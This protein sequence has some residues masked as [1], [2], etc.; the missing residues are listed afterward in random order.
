MFVFAERTGKAKTSRILV[1]S[2]SWIVAPHDGDPFTRAK[3]QIHFFA[4]FLM[5]AN[6]YRLFRA[7]HS[8]CRRTCAF[9]DPSED[10][11]LDGEMQSAFANAVFK[12]TE[13]HFG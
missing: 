5:N 12:Q 1:D 7:A 2:P 9:I 8:Q 4:G 6:P 3:I 10:G 13:N 11:F